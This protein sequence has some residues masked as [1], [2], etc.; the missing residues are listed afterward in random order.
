M[1][2]AQNDNGGWPQYYPYG[3]GYFKNIT[4]NDN[5]MPDLMESYMHFQMTA[6]LQTVNCVKITHGQEKRLRTRQIL[7]FSNSASRRYIEVSM[8]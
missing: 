1:C 6:V 2:D 7:M 4:F 5:A 8:G 3:V